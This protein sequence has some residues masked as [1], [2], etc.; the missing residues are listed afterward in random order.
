MTKEEITLENYCIIDDEFQDFEKNENQ[1]YKKDIS[2]N[3]CFTDFYYD[4]ITNYFDSK[5]EI[6]RDYKLFLNKENDRIKKSIKKQL[7]DFIL[8]FDNI[9]NQYNS[10]IDLS[11]ISNPIKFNLLED[12]SILLEWHFSDFVFSFSFEENK[13]DSFWYLLSNEKYKE[14]SYSGKI[15]DEDLNNTLIFIL[16]FVNKNS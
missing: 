16:N 1:E 5:T 4:F 2:E 9:A 12:D 8:K 13:S 10:I 11:K 15:F 6:F 14:L 3:I 7:E